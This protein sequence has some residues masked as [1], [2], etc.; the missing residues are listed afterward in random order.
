LVAFKLIRAGGPRDKFRRSRL[1]RID[2]GACERAR[3]LKGRG[4][5]LAD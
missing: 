5:S 1:R 4:R 3:S 2:H